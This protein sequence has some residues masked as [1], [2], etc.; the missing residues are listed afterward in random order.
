MCIVRLKHCMHRK[1][2]VQRENEIALCK[3]AIIICKP[4]FRYTTSS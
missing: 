2:G 4:V 3:Q 1:C